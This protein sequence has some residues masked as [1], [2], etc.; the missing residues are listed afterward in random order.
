MTEQK[1]TQA[2]PE[3]EEIADRLAARIV[4]G[5]KILDTCED[6]ILKSLRVD[7]KSLTEWGEELR[8]RL[9]R[10]DD[11]RELEKA[12]SDIANAIQKAEFVLAVFEL[13][14]SLAEN[15]HDESFARRYVSEMETRKGEGKI[16]AE[17]LKQLVLVDTTVDSSLAASQ[18]AAVVADYFKRLVKGLEEARK[19]LENKTR[20]MNLRMKFLPGT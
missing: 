1:T 8:V 7:G 10:S 2:T 20:L 9:P 6:K 16:A 4:K 13:K 5:K 18:T 14:G 12:S 19:G 15:Y 17:K 3:I 11:L